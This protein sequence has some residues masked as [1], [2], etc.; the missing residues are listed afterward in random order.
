M[1]TNLGRVIILGV[2]SG[3]ITWSCDGYLD[4][5]N[6]DKLSTDIEISPSI[7]A[8][9]AFGSFS[10]QDI[11]E[12]IND[13][14]GLVSVGDGDLIR[15]YYSDTA[16]SVYAEELIEI[17]NKIAS[18]TYIQSDVDIPAWGGIFI[19][20]QYT[21]LK[22]EVL[23]FSIEPEDRIDSILIKS[24]FLKLHTY[25]EFHHS[26]ELNIRSSNILD[27]NG[28]T[29]DIT[30]TISEENGTFED[31]SGY[32]IIMETI[33][34]EAVAVI[35]FKLTLT[36]S[37]AGISVDEEAGVILSFEDI[38]YSKVFG[39][40]ASR[41]IIEMN[42]SID[43]GFFDNLDEIPDI[44]FE[45]P[46]FN[47]AAH[48]SFGIPILL[49]IDSFRTR[50]LKDGA[51]TDLVFRNDTMNP[52]EIGAPTV[53]MLGQVVTTERNYN[54]TTTTIDE[55]LSDVPD[56][57]DFAFTA[58]SDTNSA[59]N[60]FLLDT[61]RMVIEADVILPIWFRTSGYTIRDTLDID[62]ESI[63]SDVSFIDSLGFRLTTINEWPLELS[64]QLFFLDQSGNTLSTLFQE[65]S[66]LID[67]APVDSEG[68]LEETLLTPFVVEVQKTKEDLEVVEGAR[69][70]MLVAKVVTSENL[71]PP[72]PV[73]LLSRYMLN[74]QLS[75][76][77][78]L[79]INPA[80]LDF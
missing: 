69:K 25:S 62:L 33:D 41:E 27:E 44:Y 64:V 76:Y 66:I 57:V 46:Q 29:L 11:L 37:E 5:F 67:A 12:A 32:K 36:K 40:F 2:V 53:D 21:F 51:Y 13:S 52:F 73:K 26:G 59:G 19:G 34:N 8:P 42:E 50:S 45:D 49:E 77:A 31:L 15:I 72:V 55:L 79:R 16:F 35:N 61:S 28:D 65:Q 9:T 22:D 63:L 56:K 18:E 20:E 47:I 60:H 78:D 24:G 43:I 17:P 58:K 10:I 6:L 54:K 14:S 70:M 39:H 7:A 75:V 30:F 1:K 3:F 71:N 4:Q 74:Y 48:N 80:E 23:S 68:D 38:K